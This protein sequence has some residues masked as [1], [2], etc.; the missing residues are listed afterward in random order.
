MFNP[1]AEIVL[2]NFL[3]KLD[4]SCDQF[5]RPTFFLY[6]SP[7]HQQL[8]LDNGYSIVYQKKKM[9]LESVIAMRD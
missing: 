5:P 7:Q 1:F 3:Q 4:I 8:L 6:A 9:Y 2:K